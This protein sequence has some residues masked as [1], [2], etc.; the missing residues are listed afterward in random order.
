MSANASPIYPRVGYINAVKYSPS[1]N[2]TSS[3][4]TDGSP[5]AGSGSNLIIFIAD[6]TNG[7][8]IQKIIFTPVSTVASTNTVAR[9]LRVYATSVISGGTGTDSNWWSIGEISLV[10]Q[11]TANPTSAVVSPSMNVNTNIPAGYGLVVSASLVD[12]TNTSYIITTFG[13][14]Y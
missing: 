1:L 7:S 12:T 5:T 10:I 9:V 11:S 14:H 6:V 4:D 3:K 8:Y 13:G 2:V